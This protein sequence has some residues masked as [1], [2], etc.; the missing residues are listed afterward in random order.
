MIHDTQ[1]AQISQRQDERNIYVIMKTM[2]PPR[3][4]HNGFVASDALG[5]MMYGYTLLVPMNQRVLN[6]L[7]KEHN[8][9][10]H[11]RSTT[12]RVLKYHRSKMSV[13]YMLS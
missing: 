10:G 4:H 9:S 3:N 12:H 6:K 8:I 1:S 11:K 5:H 13:M 2:C 7:S